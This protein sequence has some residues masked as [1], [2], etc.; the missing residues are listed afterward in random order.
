M[1]FSSPE[2]AQKAL[3]KN[4]MMLQGRP[5]KVDVAAER[6]PR[7]DRGGFGGGRGGGRGGFG[8]GRGG[9]F[10]GGRGGG[11]GGGDSNGFQG[12]KTVL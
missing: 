1:E 3:L 11:F 6:P 9:G 7:Q 5:L 2:E 10:G 12:K 4:G 8:G